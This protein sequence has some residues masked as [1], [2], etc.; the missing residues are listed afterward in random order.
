MQDYRGPDGK[1]YRLNHLKTSN[2]QVPV[3][4][5]GNRYLIP[6][7]VTFSAHCYTD[8]RKKTVTQ[9]DPWYFKTDST[10]DRAFCVT[11]WESSKDLPENVGYLINGSLKCYESTNGDGVYLHLRNPNSKYPG[12][13]W[14][15]MFNFKP[16]DAPALVIMGIESHHN[17]KQFPTNIKNRKPKPFAMVLEQWVSS[18]PKLLGVLQSGV[19]PG[20]MPVEP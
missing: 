9:N 10:G 16:A 2:Y 4:S 12:N 11:R 8:T 15:V 3:T 13:G 18:K 17:R 14:Y 6:I 20:T 7:V 1:S 19:L 5:G